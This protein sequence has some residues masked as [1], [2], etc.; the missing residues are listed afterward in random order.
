MAENWKYRTRSRHVS[1]WKSV[2]AARAQASANAKQFE[3][4]RWS[5]RV[6]AADRLCTWI[7]GRSKGL[8]QAG[9]ARTKLDVQDCG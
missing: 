3:L 1:V 7:Q 2:H 8:R 4:S 9:V 6:G 5:R